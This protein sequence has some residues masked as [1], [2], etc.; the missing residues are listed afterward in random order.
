VFVAAACGSTPAPASR[1]PAP[2]IAVANSG[3]AVDRAAPDS[4]RFLDAKAAYERG[5]YRD[6][7]ALYLAE[8]EALEAAHGPDPA[9]LLP[10]L[11]GLGAA[12]TK[13]AEWR[14]GEDALGRAHR[15]AVAHHGPT[16]A[17]AAEALNKLGILY[18]A[19][20]RIGEAEDAL[21]RALAIHDQIAAG[22]TDVI[23]VK[24]NLALLYSDLGRLTEAA[25][26]YRAVLAH[27]EETL[28]PDDP[29]TANTMHN[30]AIVYRDLGRYAD[31]IGLLEHA[32]DIKE[33]AL[34]REHPQMIPSL[35]ALA[36]AYMLSGEHHLAEGL[37]LHSI[38]LTGQLLGPEHPSMGVAVG[39][40]GKLYLR[41]ERTEEGRDQLLRALPILIAAR[42]EADIDSLIV[43]ERLATAHET[44]GDLDAAVQA[45]EPAFVASAEAHGPDHPDT[46]ALA[47]RIAELLRQLGR[48]EAADGYEQQVRAVR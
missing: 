34:G 6:A 13:L 31:A 43:R 33:A 28:G 45:L 4:Q 38:A 25:E 23:S 22:E 11:N 46:V 9:E 32:I 14:R 8:I 20:G 15:V 44:L 29:I 27:D 7:V 35:T 48:P 42:G 40:L 41:M 30:L 12:H 24:H 2:P 39:E 10:A 36:G 19:A 21:R 47:Q 3:D 18:L 17:Q 16:S 1:A 26:L 5:A 37:L